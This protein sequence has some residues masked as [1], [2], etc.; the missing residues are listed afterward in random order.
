NLAYQGYAGGLPLGAVREVGAVAVD[1]VTPDCTFLLDMDPARAI[2]RLERSLDRMESRSADYR[3][4]LREGFLAEAAAMGPS[5]HVI[6][7]DQDVAAVH[8]EITV[9]ASVALSRT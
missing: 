2:G 3:R 5:V 6:D 1:G 8:A 7:A 9:I 4:R